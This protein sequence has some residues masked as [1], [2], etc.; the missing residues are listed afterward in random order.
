MDWGDAAQVGIGQVQWL[1]RRVQHRLQGH[2]FELHV[3]DDPDR[4]AQVQGACLL[5]DVRSGKILPQEALERTALGLGN[6]FAGAIGAQL[7]DH[8]PVV[9]QY[10][11]DKPCGIAEQAVG[12]VDFTQ[13]RDQCAGKLDG[14]R[15][16]LAGRL[17]FQ[18]GAALE[19]VRRY[20]HTPAIGQGDCKAQRRARAF[21]Y[22]GQGIAQGMGELPAN[23]VI[24]F[25]A[26]ERQRRPQ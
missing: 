14:F 17:E 26:I 20:I 25:K 1:A 9:A 12:L 22:A 24:E 3:R 10:C 19:A 6:H 13:L 2:C 21:A 16:V 7:V 18:D 23:H 15:D 8:H 4:V 11:T 5:R